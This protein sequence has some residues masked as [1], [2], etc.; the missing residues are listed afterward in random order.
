MKLIKMIVLINLIFLG[1]CASLTSNTEESFSEGKALVAVT[2]K[3]EDSAQ[4]HQV[5]VTDNEMAVGLL[6][7]GTVSIGGSTSNTL[8]W[9]REPGIMKLKLTPKTVVKDLPAI[10]VDTEAGET[11]EFEVRLNCSPYEIKI[12]DE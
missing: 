10:V 8:I 4:A 12:I 2:R 7:V 1:G 6:G 11:Y 9:E 3:V 5:E